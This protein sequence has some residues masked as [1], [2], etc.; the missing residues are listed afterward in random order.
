M[1]RLYYAFRVS[2]PPSSSRLTPQEKSLADQ[3]PLE[4]NLLKI[5]L[6]FSVYSKHF[7]EL[8]NPT[9]HSTFWHNYL[10]CPSTE[11][12]LQILQ[13]I[14]PY[15]QWAKNWVHLFPEIYFEMSMQ[16]PH[17]NNCQ[18]NWQSKQVHLLSE[19]LNLWFRKIVFQIC[20]KK[21]HFIWHCMGCNSDVPFFLE[22]PFKWPSFI[23]L[24]TLS[25]EL[26]NFIFR[27]TRGSRQLCVYK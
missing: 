5:V 22:V 13:D 19:R 17:F 18:A 10:N 16:N 23:L 8:T 6:L 21:C 7:F 27:S 11:C 24:L 12:V 4:Q 20:L 25:D 26:T 2:R 14:T 15:R 3:F 9:L 1:H